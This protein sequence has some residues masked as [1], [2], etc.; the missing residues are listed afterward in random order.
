MNDDLKNL[1]ETLTRLK[2]MAS[3]LKKSVTDEEKIQK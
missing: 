3:E 1:Q 2:E